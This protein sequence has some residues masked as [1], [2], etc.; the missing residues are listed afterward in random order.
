MDHLIRRPA[1]PVGAR[2]RASVPAR[3]WQ[4][5]PPLAAAVRGPTRR[6]FLI[7]AASLLVLGAVG[8]GTGE[9]GEPNENASGGTRTVEHKYG[10]TE[11]SGTP[12]RVVTVGFSDQDPVLALGVKPVAVTDWYGD[13][14]YAVWPWAQGE[15][16]DAKPEV[17][18]RGKFTGATEPNFEQ[19]AALEPDLIVGMYS[20][21]SEQQYETLSEIAPT[22]PQSGEYPDYGMPWQEMTRVAGRALGKQE[23]AEEIIAGVEARFEKACGEHPEFEGKS[24]VVAERFETGFFVRAP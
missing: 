2:V 15:L 1:L 5:G 9:E 21:L 7:G 4:L 12:E 10:A 6:E 3:L 16:G 13:Y 11:V 14:P 24:A 19:V 22:V 23:R 20:G 17:L 8:C 18:N